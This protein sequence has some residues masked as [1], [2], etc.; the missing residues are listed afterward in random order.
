MSNRS[1]PAMR[2]RPR[3]VPSAE[4]EIRPNSAYEDVPSKLAVRTDLAKIFPEALLPQLPGRPVAKMTPQLSIVPSIEATVSERINVFKD[5]VLSEVIMRGVFT[6]STN[7][8]TSNNGSFHLDATPR[9]PLST[10]SESTKN[11]KPDAADRSTVSQS[12][13]DLTSVSDSLLS[14]QSDAS[15]AHQDQLS[16][17]D[18]ITEHAGFHAHA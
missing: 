16:A 1:E 18:A 12:E 6:D 17:S 14:I 4:R 9:S 5:S 3:R 13:H 7:E 15:S 8:M 10:S 11:P 2:G